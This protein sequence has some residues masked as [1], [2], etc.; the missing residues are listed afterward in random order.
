M[1]LRVCVSMLLAVLFT[2]FGFAQ[3]DTPTHEVSLGYSFLRSG[4]NRQGWVASFSESVNDRLWVKAEVGGNYREM[5]FFGSQPDFVHSLLAGPEFKLRKDAKL[6][7]MGPCS[8]RNHSGSS[9]P[10]IVL[11]TTN[12]RFAFQPGGVVDY[13]FT[14]KLGIRFG[15]DYRWSDGNFLR[16][17]SGIV[18]RFGQ[19]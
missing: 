16:L 6:V 4:V 7:T 3:S 13:H 14:P 1:K 11:R 18:Y 12:V 8:C 2:P 10:P 19:R 15:A 9:G 17:Q 5:L